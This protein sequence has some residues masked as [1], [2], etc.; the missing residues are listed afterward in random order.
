VARY[1]PWWV[2]AEFGFGDA[3]QDWIPRPIYEEMPSALQMLVR[4]RTCG[5]RDQLQPP[6]LQAVQAARDAYQLKLHAALTGG[7]E[8]TNANLKAASVPVPPPAVRLDREQLRRAGVSS[9]QLTVLG[10]GGRMPR[11]SPHLPAACCAVQC[12]SHRACRRTGSG[13][14]LTAL[15]SSKV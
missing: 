3:A 15:Q 2:T 9:L 10:D 12:W 13:S 5:V 4:H 7:G 14:H 11:P 1:V 8:R 6:K